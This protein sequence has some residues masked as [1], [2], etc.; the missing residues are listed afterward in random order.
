MR[1]INDH[2][3]RL[4]QKWGKSQQDTD[5]R[6]QSFKQAVTVAISM[7]IRPVAHDYQ[8]KIKAITAREKYQKYVRRPDQTR[9][10]S[11]SVLTEGATSE[12]RRSHARL[13]DTTAALSEPI[14]D[15]LALPELLRMAPL[16][17]PKK[18]KRRRGAA[19]LEQ[20]LATSSTEN[21]TT[22][23]KSFR[24]P[25]IRSNNETPSTGQPSSPSLNKSRTLESDQRLPP[26]AYFEPVSKDEKFVWRCAFKHA[27][28]HYYNAG[29]R[30]S[31][32]GCNTTLSDNLHVTLMDFYMPSRTF[33]FQPARNIRWKPSKRFGQ[34]RDSGF[35]CHNAVAKD[36]YWKAINTGASEEEARKMGIDA[37]F[38]YIKPKPPPKAPTPEP[39]PMPMPEPDLGPHPSGSATM[40]HGQ[41]VPDGY[42]W[43]KQ[44]PDEE[45]AW[46]CDVN[47]ALG[48]YYLAGDKKSCSGCGSSQKGPGKHKE[49][50]FYL[51][52]GVVVRQEAPGLS[53]YKPR[54][55]YKLSN[56]PAMKKEPVT[57]NQM[58]AS[59]YFELVEMGHEAEEAM[60]L[61][62][63]R[64]DTAL[65]KKQERELKRQKEQDGNK[66]LSASGK[67]R[68]SL[69]ALRK[70]SA[71]T[72]EIERRRS[73]YRRNS[74][75]GC[76]MALVPKKRSA[77]DLSE[78][79]IDEF[80][81][82][83]ETGYTS[84]E[85]KPLSSLED[86]SADEE[87]SGSESE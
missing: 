5:Y 3:R 54:K 41:D 73:R 51:P 1:L 10:K 86:S 66:G 63:E 2:K 32:R 46:R 62:V 11:G 28:G 59:A 34:P 69:G 70:D 39:M 23:S 44:R 21:R 26:N 84:S 52:S 55:P 75:G 19:A 61:A 80:A 22:A 15:Q 49:M 24:E 8:K 65:D 82:D 18:K 9:E 33:Y 38:E 4:A 43:E 13:T 31:C 68:T 60:R 72:S 40:E 12:S 67:S 56:P 76:T 27:M 6:A 29:D 81:A 25:A 16:T 7:G 87:S 85:Q 57:H 78:G 53:L 48:R 79:E 20:A 47:H 45:H 30:K 74:R 42:Y 50:D 83:E 17:R 37:V 71:N 77:N 58:C 14:P 35:S 36:A 64:V